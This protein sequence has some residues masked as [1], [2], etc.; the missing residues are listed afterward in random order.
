MLRPRLSSSADQRGGW[1]YLVL[2]LLPLNAAIFDALIAT[3]QWN[4][5][6]VTVGGGAGLQRGGLIFVANRTVGLAITGLLVGVVILGATIVVGARGPLATAATRV[7]QAT[8][9]AA[10]A[11]MAAHNLPALLQ[12]GPRMPAVV[13][14]LFTAVTTAASTSPD[15]PVAVTLASPFWTAEVVVMLLGFLWSAY[16][17]WRN[18]RPAGATAFD[19]VATAYPI[20]TCRGPPRSPR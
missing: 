13:G 12:L 2:C 7:A 11:L 18:L 17:A 19:R 14:A 3:P 6:A 4:D 9:P 5:L 16:L 15:T 10:V 20:W 8:L 1:D